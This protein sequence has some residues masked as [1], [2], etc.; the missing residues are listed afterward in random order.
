[1]KT[2]QIPCSWEVYGYLEI[3]AESLDEAIEIAESEETSLP[4]E[5]SYIE[6]S[7]SVDRDGIDID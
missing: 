5:S 1:M 6:G 4:T 7:F 3:I 2:Y